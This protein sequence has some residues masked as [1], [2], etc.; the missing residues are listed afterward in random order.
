[1][2]IEKCPKCDEKLTTLSSSG[3]AFC[4]ACKWTQKQETKVEKTKHQQKNLRFSVANNNLEKIIFIVITVVL[5]TIIVK[6]ISPNDSNKVT[7]QVAQND[8]LKVN[9]EPETNSLQSGQSQ[10]N[11]VDLQ[12]KQLN[13][14][15]SN[16]ELE[17]QS[18]KKVI[19]YLDDI[20]LKGSDGYDYW[21]QSSQDFITRLYAPRNYQ[22]LDEI[23]KKFIC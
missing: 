11:P 23:E 9:S 17:N 14:E 3:R 7:E 15:L 19:K 16:S 2:N 6:V 13:N 1:M 21:C 20:T 12:H 18:K 10:V 5:T 8:M 4:I 22:I